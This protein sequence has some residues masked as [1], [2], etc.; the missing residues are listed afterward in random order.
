LDQRL[1]IKPVQ[2]FH[3]VIEGALVGDTEI[4]QRDGVRRAEQGG[5]LGLALEPP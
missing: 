2:Q 5:G 3:H 4:V 1:Q